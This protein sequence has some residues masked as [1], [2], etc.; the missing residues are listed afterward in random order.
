[1]ASTTS[2]TNPT[3]GQEP[4]RL[5]LLPKKSVVGQPIKGSTAVEGNENKLITK[6]KYEGSN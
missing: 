4:E 2:T 5:L 6:L 3:A 1:M